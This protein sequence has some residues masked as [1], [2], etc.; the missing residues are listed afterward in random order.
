MRESLGLFRCF[1]MPDAT[2]IQVRKCGETGVLLSTPIA[3][4][5]RS[6]FSPWGETRPSVAPV[7]PF[8]QHSDGRSSPMPRGC[9]IGE[10]RSIQTQFTPHSELNCGIG[11]RYQRFDSHE[12]FHV[13][14]DTMA[15]NRPPFQEWCLHR[16]AQSR[17]V[18]QHCLRKSGG[19]FRHGVREGAL[20][21]EW[22]SR[23]ECEPSKRS[24]GALEAARRARAARPSGIVPGGRAHQ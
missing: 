2:Q 3:H 23:P 24:P 20:W 12:M 13:R 22:H 14:A 21:N 1:S 19:Q 15:R 8:L 11:I 7:F 17:P 18:E 9:G 4:R 5:C 16:A 6:I 10:H